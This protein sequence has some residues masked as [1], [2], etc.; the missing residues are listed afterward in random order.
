MP[1]EKQIRAWTTLT[2]LICRLLL[3]VITSGVFVAISVKLILDPGP[4]I[5]L[6][7]G[8]LSGTVYVMFKYYFWHADP[9]K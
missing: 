2:D 7:E 5:S 9:K 3:T 1:T 8:F 6:S 4:W